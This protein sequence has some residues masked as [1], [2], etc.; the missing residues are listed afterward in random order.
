MAVAE[1][2]HHPNKRSGNLHIHLFL[3]WGIVFLEYRQ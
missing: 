2:V 3:L 1:P